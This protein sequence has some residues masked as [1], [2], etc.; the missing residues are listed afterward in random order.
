MDAD[1]EV[2]SFILVTP[3]VRRLFVWEVDMATTSYAAGR[4]PNKVDQDGPLPCTHYGC[5]GVLPTHKAYNCHLDIHAIH[6]G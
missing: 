1:I 3:T 4:M 6:D 5:D 2:S